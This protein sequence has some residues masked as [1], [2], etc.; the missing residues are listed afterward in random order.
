MPSEIDKEIKEAEDRVLE[1]IPALYSSNRGRET[2]GV[3]DTQFKRCGV[4]VPRVSAIRH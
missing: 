3:P 1:S 2:Q 4:A